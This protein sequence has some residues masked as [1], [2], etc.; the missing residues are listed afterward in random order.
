VWLY[1]DSRAVLFGPLKS[2]LRDQYV[3]N[4]NIAIHSSPKLETYI[5]FKYVYNFELYLQCVNNVSHRIALTQLRVSSHNLFIETGRYSN[6]A[7]NMRLVQHVI[8]LL[9]KV[10]IIFYWFVSFTLILETSI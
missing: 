10:S 3:Q 6:V 9:L 1:Q 7:R 8:C 4:W 5:T 2:R